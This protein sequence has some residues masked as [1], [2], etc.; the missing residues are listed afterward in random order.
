MDQSR[1]RDLFADSVINVDSLI[2]GSLI[3]PNLDVNSI[4]YID[5]SNNLS[6][7]VLGNGNCL[8]VKLVWRL[9]L[10]HLQI[11]LIN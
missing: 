3:L 10:I 11:Q 7:I 2:I 9:Y 5:S 8:L 4:P 1:Y 6:D